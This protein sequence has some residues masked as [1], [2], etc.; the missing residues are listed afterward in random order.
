MGEQV[1]RR[2]EAR[3]W[4]AFVA[5]GLMRNVMSIS[6]TVW[7]GWRAIR[8]RRPAYEINLLVVSAD[9]RLYSSVLYNATLFNWRA[10]WVRSVERGIDIARTDPRRI[11]IIDANIETTTWSLIV[12]HFFMCCPETCLLVALPET[13]DDL[14]QLA[15]DCGAYDVVCRRL[16]A[17]HFGATVCFASHWHEN[18]RFPQRVLDCGRTGGACQQE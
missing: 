3:D 7:A 9:D 8:R 2:P 11:V 17:R 18:I 12:R 6:E 13:T 14:W 5:A 15:I 4:L 1:A 10:G 16:E